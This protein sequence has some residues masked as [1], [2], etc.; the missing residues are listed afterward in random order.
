LWDHR[1]WIP[2]H[3]RVKNDYFSGEFNDEDVTIIESNEKHLKETEGA[4]SEI[5][6]DVADA[7]AISALAPVVHPSLRK[8]KIVENR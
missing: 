2:S 8:I 1:K 4:S 6:Q 7:P 3:L 5:Q